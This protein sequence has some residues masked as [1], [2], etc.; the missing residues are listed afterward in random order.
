MASMHLHGPVSSDKT[1]DGSIPLVVE[2]IDEPF[3]DRHIRTV[4]ESAIH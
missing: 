2:E 4:R 3:D 1:V